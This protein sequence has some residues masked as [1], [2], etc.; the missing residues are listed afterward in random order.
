M[1]RQNTRHLQQPLFSDL[2]ALP[3]K[4]RR[5]L[6]ESWGGT[7]YRE[8][9]VRLDEKPFAALYSDEPSRPNTPICYGLQVR[10]ALGLRNVGEEHFELRTMY[11]FR[12]RMA[13]HM[14]ATGENLYAQTMEQIAEG[15]LEAYEK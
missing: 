15:Q 8:V 2:D 5:Q 9:F 11:N 4:L 7:F 1:Y 3:E 10:Y 12:R 13:Q 14:Q 6:D